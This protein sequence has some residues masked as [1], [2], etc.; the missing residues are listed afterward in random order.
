MVY[1]RARFRS[2]RVQL[3]PA[4]VQCSSCAR[5]G[6]RRCRRGLWGVVALWLPSRP[7]G[8]DASQRRSVNA[9]C[10]ACDAGHVL[11]GRCGATRKCYWQNNSSG[12]CGWPTP[13][14]RQP[15]DIKGRSH[16]RFIKPPQTR[17][18]GFAPLSVRPHIKFSQSCHSTSE[19]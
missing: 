8:C 12:G 10:L 7:A 15:I 5:I 19:I 13:S 1:T 2:C 4:A 17:F 3:R 14:P 9:C 11:G 16:F 6:A 18:C